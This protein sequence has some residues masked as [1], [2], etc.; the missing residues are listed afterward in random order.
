M[1]P[2]DAVNDKLV[3]FFRPALQE[4]AIVLAV[5][6]SLVFSIASFAL[7]L[8]LIDVCIFTL[9]VI[10]VQSGEQSDHALKQEQDVV[11]AVNLEFLE[12]GPSQ[13]LLIFEF[14]HEDAF[15]VDTFEVFHDTD[16]LSTVYFFIVFEQF[17]DDFFEH[18]LLGSVLRLRH[19]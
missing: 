3:D 18:A 19:K 9:V 14:L 11:K 7:T 2:P 12:E 8:S 1:T 16:L 5:V 4:P 10:F 15:L 17:L 13:I 6:V